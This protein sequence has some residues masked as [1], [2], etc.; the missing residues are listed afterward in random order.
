MSHHHVRADR[1]RLRLTALLNFYRA[2]SSLEC[3]C[4]RLL[5]DS[6]ALKPIT[7]EGAE[8]V[9]NGQHEGRSDGRSDGQ[10]KYAEQ[11]A[12][13]LPV[14]RRCWPGDSHFH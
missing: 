13:A 1:A 2:L 4:A 6:G 12:S 3:L 14:V 7:G 8:R 5:T 10:R 9:T 11:M